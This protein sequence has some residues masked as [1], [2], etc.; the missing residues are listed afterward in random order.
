VHPFF[1]DAPRLLLYDLWTDPFATKAVNDAHP[2]LVE[3]YRRELLALWSAHLA[4][5]QRFQEAADVALTQEQL[6]QLQQLGYIR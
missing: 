2:E 3:R 6:E 1:P 4:L 5:A